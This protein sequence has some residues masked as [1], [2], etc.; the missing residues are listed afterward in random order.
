M[1]SEYGFEQA[2][3]IPETA[4]YQDRRVDRKTGKRILDGLID[5]GEV[6]VFVTATNRRWLDFKSAK[7]L[8]RAIQA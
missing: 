5:A 7:R 4:V 3:W 6:E 2:K 8:A 1:T